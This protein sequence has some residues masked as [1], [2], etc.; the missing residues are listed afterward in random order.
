MHTTIK[1]FVAEL[2]K[3]R[4]VAFEEVEAIFAREWT[5][6]GFEDT[7]Q[8]E[9]YRREGLAQLRAFYEAMIAAPPN[10]VMQEKTFDLQ[11]EQDIV[12]TGR[13]DQVNRTSE[14]AAEIVDYKTGRPKSPQ[15]AK[16][17]LQLG[18]YALA[19]KEQLELTPTRLVFYNLQ[20]NEAVATVRDATQLKEAEAT[21]YEVAGNIRAGGFPAKPGFACKSCEYEPL[22]PAH[23]RL[24]QVR[25][26]A[27]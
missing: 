26:A 22:C 18:V 5:S 20:T 12:V 1:H 25:P 2:K 11:M 14:G 9:E 16:K 13:I 10:V 4:R 23:E 3:K 15:Q 17:S 24:V 8:E 21:V 27:R 6:A 7:Y 19:A